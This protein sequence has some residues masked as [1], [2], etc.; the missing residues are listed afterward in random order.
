MTKIIENLDW[1]VFI[2]FVSIKKFVH[3]IVT[4]TEIL[5]LVSL[6]S[7]TNIK[8]NRPILGDMPKVIDNLEGPLFIELAPTNGTVTKLVTWTENLALV[9]FLL[10][11]SFLWYWPT[12]GDVPTDNYSLILFQQ[13]IS[14]NASTYSV[15]HFLGLKPPNILMSMLLYDN[16]SII[17]LSNSQ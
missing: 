2:G 4:R 13:N 8:W 6:K 9:S 16:R 11:T 17:D 10:G 1:P 3:K 5:A 7:N 14:L 12:F 15:K